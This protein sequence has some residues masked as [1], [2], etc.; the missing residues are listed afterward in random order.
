LS[1]INVRLIRKGVAAV[2]V[3]GLAGGLLAACGSSTPSAK[4]ILKAGIL[5][6]RKGNYSVAEK[7]YAKVIAMEPKNA[8]AIFDLGDAEQFRK[9]YR[10]AIIHYKAALAI[11]P[12]LV[13][14]LY[15]WAILVTK[16]NPAE[17]ASLYN[18][19]I[20]ADPGY[21]Q[22]HFNLG[23]IMLAQ[24]N[25]SGALAQLKLAT[26]MDPALAKRLGTSLAARVKAAK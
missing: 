19:A 9:N 15:N 18:R 16:A 20:A 23:Y 12:K 21:A 7:D 6:Q 2:L 24:G 13:P 22:A 11:N 10:Y 3:V 26:L 1:G 17:A 25:E 4:S 8:Y 5:E 14:A